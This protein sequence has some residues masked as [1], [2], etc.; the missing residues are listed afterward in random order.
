VD[1]AIGAAWPSVE[2]ARSGLVLS[3]RV[4]GAIALKA[5]RAGV[6]FIASRSIPTTLAAQVCDCASLPIIARAGRTAGEEAVP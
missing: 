5:A 3:S 4:S 2:L 6:S 1:R